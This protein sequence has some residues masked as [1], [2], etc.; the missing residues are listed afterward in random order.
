M[1]HFITAHCIIFYFSFILKVF[2]VKCFFNQGKFSTKSDVWAFAVTMWEIL[3][4]ARKQPYADLVDEEVIKNV[5]HFFFDDGL[6]LYLPQP[7]G[8]PKEIYDLMKECWQRNEHS[9]PNFKDIHLFLQRKNLGYIPNLW[10]SEQS[11]CYWQQLQGNVHLID[12]IALKTFIPLYL[13]MQQVVALW[14]VFS[15]SDWS[16]SGLA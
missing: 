15:I 9:R 11:I 10:G 16:A 7:P 2:N 3:T 5:S 4:L 6:Q 1:L 13:K 12:W 14:Q 8:C